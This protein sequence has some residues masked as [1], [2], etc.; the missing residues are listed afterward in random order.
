MI[1]GRNLVGLTI[2]MP[3]FLASRILLLRFMRTIF[4]LGLL[5]KFPLHRNFFIKYIQFF[6]VQL[7]GGLVSFGYGFI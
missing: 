5:M 2:I 7:T 1:S 4:A 6:V 3:K